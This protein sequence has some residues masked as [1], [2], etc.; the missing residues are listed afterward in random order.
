MHTALLKELTTSPPLPTRV[1]GPAAS[2]IRNAAVDHG[3]EGGLLVQKMGCR[4][5]MGLS[6]RTPRA[7]RKSF[8]SMLNLS[9]SFS[10]S[11]RFDLQVGNMVVKG[12]VN[13]SFA[14]YILVR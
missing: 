4:D 6:F 13:K 9:S 3:R 14:K 2:S 11:I 12:M 10:G 1:E 7:E 5:P 8:R